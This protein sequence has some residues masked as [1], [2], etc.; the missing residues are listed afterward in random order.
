MIIE[1]NLK[2]VALDGGSKGNQGKCT[3]FRVGRGQNPEL[4][5]LVALDGHLRWAKTSGRCAE[6]AWKGWGGHAQ[7]A[8]HRPYAQY[9]NDPRDAPTEVTHTI[10]PCRHLHALIGT[11]QSSL[12]VGV[13]MRPEDSTGRRQ[14]SYE[15]VGTPQ[16]QEQYGSTLRRCQANW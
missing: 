9:A 3:H 12:A 2:V 6:T 10:T 8:E 14:D 15:P 11:Q 5:V 1:G 4:I 13:G 16:E 7:G